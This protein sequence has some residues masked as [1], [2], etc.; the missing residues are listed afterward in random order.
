FGDSTTLS[1]AIVDAVTTIPIRVGIITGYGT[2]GRVRIDTEDI[3]YTGT[4]T[5]L[6]T[7]GSTQPCLTGI[8][9]GA[10]GTTA[11]AHLI[12]ASVGNTQ[13]VVTLGTPV[14]N[15]NNAVAFASVQA[16]GAQSMGRSFFCGA[17]S[18]CASPPATD[19]GDVDILGAAT[20]TMYLSATNQLT[21]DRNFHTPPDP[22][23]VPSPYTSASDVGWYVVEFPA[24]G[25][26]GGGSS[27]IIDFREVYN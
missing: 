14:S 1:A 22:G 10:N 21:I 11:A 18:S 8:T 12:N 9:R 25:G 26:G 27:S 2:A 19:L 13:K 7:C 17:G 20:F 3:D 24:S 16:D 23:P 4:S 5:S 6:V 15:I